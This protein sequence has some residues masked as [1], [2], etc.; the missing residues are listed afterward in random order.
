M[1][2]N[3]DWNTATY[4]FKTGNGKFDVEFD[5]LEM[6]ITGLTSRKAQWKMK[7][8]PV[9]NAVGG[10]TVFDE[11]QLLAE[12]YQEIHDSFMVLMDNTIRFLQNAN[13]TFNDADTNAVGAA[14]R[15]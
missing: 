14:V 4:G 13:S 15:K 7:K 10:G 2:D 3:M 9:P 6:G 11:V 8:M 5:G 1:R 12:S